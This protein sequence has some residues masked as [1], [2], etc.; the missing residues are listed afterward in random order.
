MAGP[1]DRPAPGRGL[2]ARIL[3]LAIAFLLLGEVLIYVPSIARFRLT[4][5]QE[6]LAAARLASLSLEVPHEGSLPA[7]LEAQLLSHA[8]VRS[9]TLWAP[10]AERM[11]GKMMPVDRVYDLRNPT[12]A[13]LV[14]DSLETLAARPRQLIRVIGPSPMDKDM[15]IDIT[16]DED[17]LRAAMLDYSRRIVELS[18]VLSGIM[19]TLLFLSLRRMIVMPLRSIT[20]GLAS[21]RQRPE[22]RSADRRPS[23]RADEIGIVE[24]ELADMQRD[25]RQALAQKTR[26]AALG[27]AVGK[28][29]H[30]LKN[31]LA[32]AVLISD[33]LEAS[34]DPAV[35][36][37]AP[38]LVG[39]LDRA[40]RLCIDTLGFAR[41]QP[42]EPS[43]TRF[44][45]P[46]LLDE[47]AE[48]VRA[49][50]PWLTWRNEGPAGLEITADRDQLYRVLLNLG[51][52]S[53]EAMAESGGTVQVSV[54][55]DPDEV[56]VI[57]SDTGSGISDLVLPQLFATFS[58]STKPGGSGL[59]LA[60]CRE[61]MRAHGG[62]VRLVETGPGGT[63]FE[64]I[65]PSRAIAGTVAA[66]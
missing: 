15:T 46:P 31:I 52:N 45:L 10:R 16:L 26:L 64:L 55:Q 25:L 58:G 36:K 9:I 22:D 1:S 30:D 50:S 43:F 8:G 54:V 47:V 23:G 57:V 66:E 42:R 12:P 35:R 65:L 5:L 33:R 41:E 7:D 20:Q 17:P 32:S 56:R 4:Y 39:S 48:T 62:D 38:R 2:S 6:H 14:L 24:R 13:L 11:L 61:I 60:I 44:A 21:F 53:R 29:S 18:F 19:A 49:D 34:A 40:I 28:L 51:R 59:G 3:L 37:V 27:A 63:T